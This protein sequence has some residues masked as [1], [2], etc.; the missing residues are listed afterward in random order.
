MNQES[1]HVN[2]KGLNYITIY[3]DQMEAVEKFYGNVLGEP[4]CKGQDGVL[5]YC[6][7]GTWVTFVPASSKAGSNFE[8]SLQVGSP[9]E[10]DALRQKFIDA[11][12]GGEAVIET[13]MYEWMRTCT[14]TDPLGMK[15]GIYCPIQEPAPSDK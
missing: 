12:G 13:W 11:G 2:I 8:F 1:T 14:V 5:G 15:V 3:S 9:Q 7:G 6:F 10:V 4:E